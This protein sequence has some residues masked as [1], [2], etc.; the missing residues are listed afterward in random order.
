MKHEHPTQLLVSMGEGIHGHGTGKAGDAG[1]GW[2]AD[3]GGHAGHAGGRP[4]GLTHALLHVT[5]QHVPPLEL[6]PAEL[7]GVGGGDATLVPLVPDQGCLVEVGP[8]APVA[9]VFVGGGVTRG[10]ADDGLLLGQVGPGEVGLIHQGGE[11]RTF[12]W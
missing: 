9:R 12:T 3:H 5:L 8:A 10:L 4:A 7:A 6:P 11:Y 1:N 2:H